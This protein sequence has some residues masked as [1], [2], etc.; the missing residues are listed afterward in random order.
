M[1]KKSCAVFLVGMLVWGAFAQAADWYK[2]KEIKK[3]EFIGLKQVSATTMSVI[4]E[5]YKGQVLSDDV[6]FEILN[7]LYELEYFTDDIV[8]K[9][10]PT[11][12][13]YTA[14]N[15]Q[16]EVKERPYIAGYKFTGANRIKSNE[17]LKV[18]LQ[19]KNDIFNQAKAEVD[20][21]TV[22]NYL[23]SKGFATATVSVNYVPD[24]EAN[25]ITIEYTI[26]EGK[27]TVVKEI[28]FE[29]A[30]VFTEKRLQKALVTKIKKG[31]KK[32]EYLAANIQQDKLNIKQLYGEKG[33]ANAYVETV[34]EERDETSDP[35][36]NFV[37]LVYV[38]VE[39][40]QFLFGGVQF[41]GNKI[42][43]SEELSQKIK[44]KQGELLNTK[45]LM[46]GFSAIGDTYY[47]NGYI[48]ANVQPVQRLDTATN[49]MLFDVSIFEGERAHIENIIVKGNTKTKEK[50][51]TRE[52]MVEEGDV[53][54]KSKMDSSLRNLYNL[55]YFSS[56]LPEMKPASERNLV[57][58][59]LNVEEQ[60]TANITFGITFSGA[61]DPNAFPMS[62]FF[63]YSEKNFLGMG[64][65]FDVG[66][67]AGPEEQNLNISY[68]ENWFLDS[69][70]S[71][72]FNTGVKHQKIPTVQDSLYPF[73][74][75]DPY[76]SEDNLSLANAYSMKYDRWELNFGINSGYSW[77]PSF[78]VITLSGGV[79]FGFVK[80]VYDSV[81]FRP[82]DPTIRKEQR[83]WGFSNSL[84]T[85]LSLDNRDNNYDPSK[86][87]F[88]SQ[89]CAFFG[90][91]PKIENEYFFRSTTKGEIYFTLLDYPVSSIWNLKFVLAFYSG[92]T[93]Q[94]PLQ[95]DP[96]GFGNK[97]FIDGMFVG[98]GWS[99]LGYSGMGDVLLDHWVEFRMPLA[100]NILAFDF[101]FEAAAA[102]RTA[103]DLAKLT[104][105]DYYFS[106][107]P[108][109]RFLL[110]QFPLKLML[111]NTF[112]SD[113]G[114][115]YWSNGKGPDWQFVLSFNS[116]NF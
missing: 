95:K 92:L 11:D 88:L 13:Q 12:D 62:L 31:F 79:N 64:S 89:Q 80:N 87:W 46:E 26:V 78:G 1:L 43:S 24:T 3:I 109:L 113:H 48:Y 61:S 105:N 103:K 10:F 15:L 22:Q 42:F 47:E 25:S 19:K 5:K 35:E 65:R 85:K 112:R 86:G 2:D 9:V 72:G 75:A 108:G 14:V 102:K 67:N 52:L 17:L 56:I 32:G 69:P 34:K 81:H 100:P 98:R 82:L 90:I 18:I 106:F 84:Y 111:A 21:Q 27:Q 74:V 63:N 30:T 77:F 8:P 71:V 115:P 23:I 20:K 57:D 29:G 55:Q 101:F 83:K 36:Q 16:F 54:S 44:L 114:K 110:P 49:Q 28:S 51:I 91:V 107:G 4:F 50:V 104:I 37:K 60:Q 99:S 70:L 45:K 39:G 73:G 41:Y 94:T 76:T 38:V 7:K 53:F 96:I 66:L 68:T 58:V 93:V 97:L 59:I 33:Y 40:Q 116:P 6:Y